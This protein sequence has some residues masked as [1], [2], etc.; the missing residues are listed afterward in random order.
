MTA[1]PIELVTE[2]KEKREGAAV[3]EWVKDVAIAVLAVLLILLVA[4][5]MIA[6]RRFGPGR[7]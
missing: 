1:V 5:S 6:N 4:N 3:P 2:D 7:R